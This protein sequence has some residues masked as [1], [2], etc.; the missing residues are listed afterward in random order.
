MARERAAS[1]QTRMQQI[2]SQRD[3][4]KTA[5]KPADE[6]KTALDSSTVLQSIDTNTSKSGT[7]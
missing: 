4:A 6:L 2:M 7:A 1:G 3:T 5:S